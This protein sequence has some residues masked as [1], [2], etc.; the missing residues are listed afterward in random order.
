MA[1][2]QTQEIASIQFFRGVEAS[3]LAGI[4]DRRLRKLA[5]AGEIEFKLSGRRRL[6]ALQ[7]LLNTCPGVT[8]VVDQRDGY[9]WDSVM[10]WAKELIERKPREYSC[11][12]EL[13][14]SVSGTLA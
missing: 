13:P 8:E 12:D 14:D 9:R 11:Q 6:Y 7:S 2:R 1:R 4:S 3:R 5:E 10:Q